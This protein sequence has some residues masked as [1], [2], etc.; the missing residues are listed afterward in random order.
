MRLRRRALLQLGRPPLGDER[1]RR[2][3][4]CPT[5]APGARPQSACPTETVHALLFRPR[6]TS[7]SP[8]TCSHA[9][10]AAGSGRVAGDHRRCRSELPSGTESRSAS[11]A[12][13]LDEH[14][15]RSPS[16]GLSHAA[17]RIVGSRRT[18]HESISGPCPVRNPLLP[19]YAVCP[20]LHDRAPL[21]EQV[22]RAHTRRRSP[23]PPTCASAE[24]REKFVHVGSRTQSL[25]LDRENASITM[26]AGSSVP[27]PRPIRPIR[28]PLRPLASPRQPRLRRGTRSS[29]RPPPRRSRP[30]RGFPRRVSVR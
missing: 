20:R 27:V 22:R 6:V 18:P 14:P 5:R 21:L 13:M 24:L 4:A 3:R 9:P 2:H 15:A 29:R 30:S 1:A 7:L 23:N 10:Q 16:S 17:R 25:K 8:A 12:A 26:P 19:R 11:P 28:R